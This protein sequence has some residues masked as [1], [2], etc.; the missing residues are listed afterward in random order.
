MRPDFDRVKFQLRIVNEK[1][2]ENR[3]KKKRKEKREKKER[4][5]KKKKLE[6]V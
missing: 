4:E 2:R 5:K 3:K 1:V 6:C